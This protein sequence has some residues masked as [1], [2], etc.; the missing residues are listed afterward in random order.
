MEGR[1]KFREYIDWIEHS[2]QLDHSYPYH[3][4]EW[5]REERGKRP[6]TPV[7]RKVFDWLEGRYGLDNRE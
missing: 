5:F 3:C 2:T 7:E 4:L 6:L 1:L